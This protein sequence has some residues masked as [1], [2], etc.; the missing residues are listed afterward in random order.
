MMTDMA[1]VAAKLGLEAADIIPYGRDKAK[2]ERGTLARLMAQPERGKLILV[3]AISPTPAGEGKTTTSIGLADGLNL[4]GHKAALALREPSLGPC[5]GAKGGA[6]GG[7]KAKLHPATDINLHFTGDFHAITSAHNLLAAL[8]DN[9]L[10]FGNP[11]GLDVRKISWPRVVD[12]NDR[13]LRRL[14]SGLGDVSRETSFDITAASEIMALLCLAENEADARQRLENIVVGWSSKDQPILAKEFGA[15]GAMLALLR[16]AMLP[17]LV[18]TEE[19][20][21]AL[22]HGGPFANIAH[23]CNSVIAT[24]AALRCADYVVTEAGFGA[25][26][27]A[28]KFLH[29]KSRSAGLQPAAAVL[30]ATVRALKYHGRGTDIP[31]LEAGMANLVR[32][33]DNLQNFGMPVVVALN[34]FADDTDEEINTVQHWCKR[35]FL[36]C[37]P[38][39]HFA[40]GGAGATALAAEVVKQAREPITPRY[41]YAPDTSLID[42]VR[43]VAQKIY[44]AADIKISPSAAKTAA[45]F[46][47]AGYGHLPVCIAKTQYSFSAEPELLGAPRGHVPEVRELRLAAGAGFIVALLG[48]IFTM[49]GLP[50]EPAAL[51]IDVDAHGVIQGV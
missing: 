40:D 24:K 50:R 15:V 26:L 44:G 32:H 39:T 2:I 46:A 9:S 37:V 30:V 19:G 29:L 21:P 16:D 47:A 22:I 7:G 43:L 48:D 49:P 1:A 36:P 17:N 42:K 23:G 11:L 38:A 25:D 20:S 28:E 12:M 3:T 27:G 6:V 8:V 35:N 10:H 14:I 13:S 4:L 34:R 31:A 33:A 5:F 18:Q 45:R 41:L 51:R